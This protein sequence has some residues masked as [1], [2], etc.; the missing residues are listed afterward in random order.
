MFRLLN[1]AANNKASVFL[2]LV[3]NI[4]VG[5]YTFKPA[6]K[7]AAEEVRREKEE[8]KNLSELKDEQ[9][10]FFWQNFLVLKYCFSL[11]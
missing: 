3:A 6:V 2:L 1:K 4:G 7:K 8:K 5:I 9:Q 10:V 11:L